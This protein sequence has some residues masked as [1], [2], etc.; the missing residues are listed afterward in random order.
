MA[1]ASKIAFRQ[2]NQETYLD[3]SSE[4]IA[5]GEFLD[6]FRAFANERADF[7]S[8]SSLGLILPENLSDEVLA[9]L[10]EEIRKTLNEKNISLRS[11][12]ASPFEE[13]SKL[14]KKIQKAKKEKIS[15]INENEVFYYKS[16]LRSGQQIIHDGDVIVFGDVN[17]SA[18]IIASGDVIVWGRLRGVVHAG[19][20]GNEKSLIAALNIGSAQL[21]IAN[22]LLGLESKKIK[23][24]FSFAKPSQVGDSRGKTLPQIA[25]IVDNELQIFKSN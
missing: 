10:T 19:A 5:R 14:K 25:K 4:D 17:N 13:K 18:E 16:N 22:K 21:R 15:I 23:K 3:L 8:G 1:T 24:K 6:E 20:R 11:S 9:E 12:E 2:I 7:L